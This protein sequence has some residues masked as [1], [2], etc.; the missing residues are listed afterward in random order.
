MRYMK[1]CFVYRKYGP[2][3]VLY[4]SKIL[5]HGIVL[6]MT[7]GAHL[8]YGNTSWVFLKSSIEND[9][10]SVQGP[11]ERAAVSDMRGW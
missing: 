4:S 5:N 6:E 2:R 8:L 7:R 9:G 10:S 3:F 11:S 1:L